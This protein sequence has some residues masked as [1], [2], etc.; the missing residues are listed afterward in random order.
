YKTKKVECI[1]NKRY[2]A[3]IS[4]VLKPIN[5]TQSILNIDGDIIGEITNASLL[6]ETFYRDNR[7]LYKPFFGKL[8][9][10]LCDLVDTSKPRNYLEKSVMQHLKKFTNINHSCPY[11]GHL[12]ARNLT[13][14]VA[15]FPPL[16]L[17]EYK[18]SF[19]CI[20]NNPSSYLGT[21]LLY[22]DVSEGYKKKRPQRN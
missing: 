3:N 1:G 11:S 5:W 4:C 15:S 19:K 20:Q 17:Q 2:F 10:N 22:F 18:L 14:D 12:F 7:N 16:P 6:V 13:L 9:F 21:M 8:Q